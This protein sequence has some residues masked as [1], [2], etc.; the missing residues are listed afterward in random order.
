MIAEIRCAGVEKES[1]Y[2]R[3][4][5]TAVERGLVVVVSGIMTATSKNHARANLLLFL[6]LMFLVDYAK[7]PEESQSH[8]STEAPRL[9]CRH[10]CCYYC[11][12]M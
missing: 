4:S 6:L 11:L 2:M 12:L 7:K 9:C 5:A 3:R 1:D 10:D 8:N